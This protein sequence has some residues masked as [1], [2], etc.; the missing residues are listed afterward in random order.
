MTLTLTDLLVVLTT[1]LGGSGAVVGLAS[2][3]GSIWSSRI[4]ARER[5]SIDREFEAF[6]HQ[7]AAISDERKD[8]GV[9]RRDVYTKVATAM[10]VFLSS[11]VPAT[12]DDKKK[13]LEAYDVACLWASENVA[14]AIGR[15]IDLMQQN[16]ANPGSVPRDL[17]KASYVVCMHEMRR[18]TGFPD[19]KFSY[20]VVNF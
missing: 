6:R 9:R 18:D 4:A 15:F 13:F 10:R 12:P 11:Q 5:A 7:L 19:T 17:L 1:A 14:L 16:T 3:L 8:A 2:W 20:R